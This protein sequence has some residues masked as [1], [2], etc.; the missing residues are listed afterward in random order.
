M[1]DLGHNSN[2]SP[3]VGGIAAD[4]LLSIVQRH[5]RLEEE[6]KALRSDQRDIMQ[7]AKSAG[8]DTAVLRQVIRLRAMDSEKRD[9][10]DHLLELYRRAVGI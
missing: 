2:A 4:H 1:P 10:R 6:V 3:E 8:F 5:E 7:E 9:E